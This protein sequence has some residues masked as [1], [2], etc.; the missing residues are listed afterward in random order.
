M[1]DHVEGHSNLEKVLLYKAVGPDMS[2]SDRAEDEEYEP[3][4]DT[5]GEPFSGAPE[6]INDVLDNFFKEFTAGQRGEFSSKKTLI[7]RLQKDNVGLKFLSFGPSGEAP[8]KVCTKSRFDYNDKVDAN[9]LIIDILPRPSIAQLSENKDVL[10]EDDFSYSCKKRTNVVNFTAYQNISP[11]DGEAI[12][13]AIS[14]YLNK[15][16]GE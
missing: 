15:K 16:L 5:S 4:V 10:A 13:K 11:K 8:S 12:S 3:F 7:K 9:F 2:V 6:Q 14:N 1:K